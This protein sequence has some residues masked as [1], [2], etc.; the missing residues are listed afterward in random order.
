MRLKLAV[1]L[2]LA[3]ILSPLSLGQPSQSD[4]YKY[5]PLVS[6]A[7]LWN[8]IRYLHPR[9][10][11]DSTA[12]DNALLAALPKIE[13]A[14]ADD[15]LAAA[16]DAM[17]DTLHDPCTRIA[18]GL[19]G[20]S[21]SVQSFDPDTM[22]IHTGNGDL[23]GSVGAGLMLKMGI[24]Q[25]SNLVWD[26]RGSRM[27]FR[28]ATRPDIHQLLLNGIGYAYREH[29]GYPPQEG[30]G[31]RHYFSSLQIVEPQRPAANQSTAARRQV[32]LIDKDSAI[33]AQA[34]IDQVNGRTAILSED[35]PRDLQAGF[36]ELV[37]I[38]GKVVAEVRVAEL[39]YADGTTEFAPSR[40][41]LNRGE[42]AVK[43]AVSAVNGP[44]SM[45]GERPKFQP[46]TSAFRDMP[47]AADPYPSRE[48]R[49][50]AAMRI[51][52][53][54]H[55]FDPYIS[56]LGDKW[57]DVLVEFLPKFSEAK[58]ARAYHL[59]VTE[60]VARSGDIGAGSRSPQI[61]SVFG[62]ASAP[63]EVRFIEKQPVITRIFKPGPGLQG[64]VILK[65]D[66]Q[67]VQHRIDDLSRYIA[68][69]APLALLSQVGHF[70]L[71]G[72][73]DYKMNLTVQGKDG[74]EREV[75]IVLNEANRRAIPASRR[76]EPIRLINQ[77]IGYA[78]MERVESAELDGMFEKFNQTAAIIFDLR[79]YPRDIALAIAARLG[80]RNHPVVA[81]LFR[82]VVG[83]GANESHISVT[84]SEL[85][86]SRTTKPRYP[87]KT[88]A[89]IDDVPASLTGESAMC[90]KAANNTVLIGSAAFPTFSAYSTRFDV[91]GGINV[92]FSGQI[93]RWPGGKLVYPQGLQP[94]VEVH[95]TI[96][97]IRAGRDEILEEAVAYLEKN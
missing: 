52:G 74:A 29:S 11:G 54:L 72:A 83:V 85:R 78:D 77:R 37:P 22:V 94:D 59:A 26:L 66:G 62:P 58:D 27:P 17:L 40:V 67:P 47:Y 35:P 15:E 1:L 70:L 63:F 33:P 86:L 23:A 97:A 90:L 32:Y 46:G 10:A 49:I 5:A 65:I 38:L 36:T 7:K 93:P 19:S 13:A 34:I 61:Q 20:K 87:G 82:N 75:P 6:T 57:D 91:P 69:P 92:F 8:M 80:N 43:A 25:T 64:D 48:M 45:P 39:R 12:W 55:Y 16:L 56:V 24:P 71:T 44:L 18:S 89:L 31:L 95:P 42:E 53:I 96:A 14:H 21:V 68:T 88:V 84:Q 73:S 2:F 60:M 28:L 3:S 4:R 30:T 50:L 81:E 76:E 9:V 41:V 51:W 79:G